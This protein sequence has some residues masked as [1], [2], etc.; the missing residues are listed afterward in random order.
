MTKAEL[1]VQFI[2]HNTQVNELNAQNKRLTSLLITAFHTGVTY[3]E[4]HLNKQEICKVM[5]WTDGQFRYRISELK[6]YGMTN[7]GGYRMGY[8][9]LQN[10]IK[11][12][13]NNT[14]K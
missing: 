2:R 1:N 14:I 12:L 3:P 9:N 7:K 4:Q 5:G 10:Y 6:Q 11:T 8:I 13:K